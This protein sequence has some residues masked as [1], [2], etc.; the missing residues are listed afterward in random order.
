MLT[1]Q[2]IANMN[3]D[4]LFALTVDD[5]EHFTDGERSMI[6]T[7]IMLADPDVDVAMR[8][9]GAMMVRFAD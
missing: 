9:D 8:T 2:E 3:T 5:V 1:F 7:L 6:V 4:E